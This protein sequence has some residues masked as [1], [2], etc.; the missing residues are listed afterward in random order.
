MSRRNTKG[1]EC[2]NCGSTHDLRV[3]GEK[4]ICLCGI[5]RKKVA[6]K[7]MKEISNTGKIRRRRLPD[8]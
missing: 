2:N 4:K 8:E 5:C 3:F 7:I 1:L 6:D